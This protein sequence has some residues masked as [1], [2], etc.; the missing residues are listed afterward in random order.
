MHPLLDIEELTCAPYGK[1]ILNVN[2]V[3]EVA[4]RLN[5]TLLGQGRHRRTYLAPHS[6]FV[7]KFP[8][9]TLGESANKDEHARWHSFK[10]KPDPY[11]YNALYT[12]CR[13]INNKILLMWAATAI[14]GDTDADDLALGSGK[15]NKLSSWDFPK[16]AD[17]ID[18][19]QVGRLRNGKVTAY[20][21]SVI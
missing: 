1:K 2:E 16:W 5:F 13:L 7:L 21:F 3:D 10:N 6:R 8:L 19:Y 9:D 20:D 14:G 11:N 18:A 4:Q 17:Y 15:L 12:P